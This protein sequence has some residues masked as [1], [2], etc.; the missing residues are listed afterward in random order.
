VDLYFSGQQSFY[1]KLISR[2]NIQREIDQFRVYNGHSVAE[3][4]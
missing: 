2:S 4:D 1:S 3:R